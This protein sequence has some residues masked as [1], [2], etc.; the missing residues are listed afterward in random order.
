MPSIKQL[1][2]KIA[3]S[4]KTE[5]GNLAKAA[6]TAGGKVANEYH[7]ILD[8]PWKAARIAT[9]PAVAIPSEVIK[10]NFPG[11]WDEANDRANIAANTAK[12][13]AKDPWRAAR[14]IVNPL[15]EIVKA[16]E[17]DTYEKIARVINDPLSP[18]HDGIQ[19]MSEGGGD[20]YI[21]SLG[22]IYDGLNA[23][24]TSGVGAGGNN[25][26]GGPG[27][28]YQWMQNLEVDDLAYGDNVAYAGVPTHNLGASALDPALD[29]IIAGGGFTANDK[30][31]LARLRSEESQAD[32]GRREAI[33]NNFAARGMSGTPNDML[34]QLSSSQAAT[35]RDAQR[36]LD[37]AGMAQQRSF[38]AK[39]QKAQAADEINRFNAVN[40]Q[41]VA[42][43]NAANQYDAAKFNKQGQLTT[44]AQNVANQT[45]RRKFNILG[46]QQVAD[47]NRQTARSN[48]Q[49]QF[50]NQLAIADRKAAA[51]KAQ[52]EAADRRADR[53]AGIYSNILASGT[54]LGATGITASDERLKKEIEPIEPDE[55]DEFFEALIPST[56]E[57][58]DGRGKGEKPG[59]RIGLIAQDIE[60]TDLGKEIVKKD[61]DGMRM[62]DTQNL[63]GVIL[64]ALADERD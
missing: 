25:G 52:A 22:G 12:D 54:K 56:Y 29:E 43:Q 41:N 42:A 49:Q 18:I 13:I 10:A 51:V 6:K 45:D 62:L 15:G 44:Q 35:T 28:N 53:K 37:T 19:Q 33:M 34:A 26:T 30:A 63:L 11:F 20:D 23:P 17:P 21:N 16:N 5:G 36:S 46:S 31:Q 64:A 59:I 24:V 9:A 57:Y 1:G 14:T 3:K 50:D 27:T 2:G 48:V 55:L 32:R 39:V 38:D 7:E 8:D 40:S 60:D 61:E 58:K 47:T 4:V